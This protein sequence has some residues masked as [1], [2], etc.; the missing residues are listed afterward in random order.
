MAMDGEC[1]AYDGAVYAKDVD[2]KNI[3]YYIVRDGVN[4]VRMADATRPKELD[5]MPR[6]WAR[7]D[8]FMAHE[9]ICEDHI[10][11]LIR[12]QFPE[13]S[14]KSCSEIRSIV[15]IPGFDASHASITIELPR[16]TEVTR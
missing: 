8:A 2:C 3:T 16:A 11:E 5:A 7:Y 15:S 13:L 6:S 9:R 12:S 14:D 10:A 1:Y 4:F